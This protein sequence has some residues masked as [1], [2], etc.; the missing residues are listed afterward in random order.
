MAT[1]GIF[2]YSN[3]D[4]FI[5]GIY[6]YC[7][8]MPSS[9]GE[10]L[11][12]KLSDMTPLQRK[13]FFTEKLK[14]RVANISDTQQT[15]VDIL[16]N[17]DFVKMAPIEVDSDKDFFRNGFCHYAYVYDIDSQVLKFYQNNSFI[18]SID[19]PKNRT[20]EN[21]IKRMYKLFDE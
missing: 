16:D 8:S 4:G 11:V 12:I 2:G 18:G 1:K 20:K 15:S 10:F 9:L 3:K 19:F 13:K 7:D 21:Q 14:F 5:D 17:K 6:S